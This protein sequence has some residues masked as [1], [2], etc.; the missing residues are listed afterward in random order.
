MIFDTKYEELNTAV[1]VYQIQR[2]VLNLLSNAIKFTNENG[3]VEL[4]IYKGKE[5]IIIEVK[6]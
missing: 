6:R 2:V 3:V 1:D 5:D 4:S